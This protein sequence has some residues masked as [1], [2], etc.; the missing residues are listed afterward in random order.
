MKN[1]EEWSPSFPRGP[2][3][4]FLP[5]THGINLLIN[6]PCMD[7]FPPRLAPP[8]H[9]RCLLGPLSKETT[10]LN[11][12][13]SGSASRGSQLKTVSKRLLFPL[14]HQC[15]FRPFCHVIQVVKRPHGVVH[16]MGP[17][18]A[19]IQTQK[20]TLGLST[21]LFLDLRQLKFVSLNLLIGEIS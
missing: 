18:F 11:I 19:D 8:L 13:H 2:E 1:S 20:S 3:W 10:T 4:N 6:T 17:G 21:C 12:L 14:V 15:C 7:L 9:W 5:L 16:T